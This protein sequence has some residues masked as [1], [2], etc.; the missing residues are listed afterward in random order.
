MGRVRPSLPMAARSLGQSR[1]ALQIGLCA[2]DARVGRAQRCCLVFVDCVK[3]LPATLILRPF[4]FD[5]LATRAY[6]QASLEQIGDAALGPDDHRG[7]PV[8]RCSFWRE[9]AEPPLRGRREFPRESAAV[10][11]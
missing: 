11:L 7:R 2:P 9:P 3:E 1:G 4:N 10:P 8:R 6:E 5:T